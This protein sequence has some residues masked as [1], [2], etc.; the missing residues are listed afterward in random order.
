MEEG[1]YIDE[2]ALVLQFLDGAMWPA[3]G[4]SP[5]AALAVRR[6]AGRYMGGEECG[7]VRA[8]VAGM[9]LGAGSGI[10]IR[11]REWEAEAEAEMWVGRAPGVW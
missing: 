8:V 10:G 3:L 5:P 2:A 6:Q 9:G 11:R 7:E 1:T 4:L